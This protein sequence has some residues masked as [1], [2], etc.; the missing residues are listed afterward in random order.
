MLKTSNETSSYSLLDYRGPLSPC[1]KQ[2]AKD[3]QTK[4]VDNWNHVLWSDESKINF[5]GS[6]GVKCVWR[7]PGEENKD[8]CEAYS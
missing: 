8:K 3:K 5:F 6:D 7:Q 4:D 2:F 1:C